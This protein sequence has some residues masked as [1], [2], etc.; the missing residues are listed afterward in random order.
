MLSCAKSYIS[1]SILKRM[2]TCRVCKKRVQNPHSFVDCDVH[3]FCLSCKGGGDQ[4]PVC[5]KSLNSSTLVKQEFFEGILKTSCFT[6]H[7]KDFER[8]KVPI[9]LVNKL[10]YEFERIHDLHLDGFAAKTRPKISRKAGRENGVLSS[11]SSSN[12]VQ[13]KLNF[14][15]NKEEKTPSDE[16]KLQGCAKTLCENAQKLSQSKSP[17]ARNLDSE[18]NVS[19]GNLNAVER[20]CRESSSSDAAM[21]SS[22]KR[23]LTSNASYDKKSTSDGSPDS[24]SLFLP[25]KYSKKA[26]PKMLNESKKVINGRA[27][28]RE[29]DHEKV[30]LKLTSVTGTEKKPTMQ[31]MD[32]S[33]PFVKLNDSNPIINSKD[34]NDKSIIEKDKKS[35]NVFKKNAKG[36]TTL[37]IAC[38]M[39]KISQL[40]ELL[41]TDWKQ[42][43]NDKDFAGWTPL[44][45]AVSSG[46]YEIAKILLEA[47]AWVFVPGYN[48]ETVLHTALYKTEEFVKLMMSYKPDVE[49]RTIYGQTPLSIAK[50]LG[51]EKLL[52]FSGKQ[53][54]DL[55]Y[56]SPSRPTLI[57]IHDLSDK[58]II[59]SLKKLNVPVAKVFSKDVSHVILKT[60]ENTYCEPAMIIL[61]AILMG[62]FLISV[63]WIDDSVENGLVLECEH[64]EVKGVGSHSGCDAPHKARL[65]SY[66]L[67]YYR[68]T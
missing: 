43:I 68:P 18:L 63:K 28:E 22:R 12:T 53:E 24:Q 8:E 25:H 3:F 50:E 41:E 42:H 38:R 20:K 62:K 4:C 7:D 17:E 47:G 34:K 26:T 57:Y 39:N 51:L 23:K 11:E 44:H 6:T 56:P 16:I 60:S 5:C 48:F 29:I 31:V 40:K 37:H 64:Y 55:P 54:L 13:I 32:L 58:H 61:E 49:A 66:R 65:N 14:L 19:P 1:I 35:K 67:T 10:F 15:S 45:E 30:K 52:E 2:L 21:N 46:N 27:V 9:H 36:E 33:S 59:A